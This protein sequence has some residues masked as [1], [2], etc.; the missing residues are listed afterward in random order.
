MSELRAATDASSGATESSAGGG[1]GK[2]ADG[3]AGGP[4]GPVSVP[5]SLHHAHGLR[6]QCRA[7]K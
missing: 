7:I 4:V 1:T 6:T 2:T 3:A 5:P